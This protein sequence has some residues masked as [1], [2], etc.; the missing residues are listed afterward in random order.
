MT[1]NVTAF[2]FARGGSKGF[3]GKNVAPLAGKP[4]I[5]HAI[6][7]A[8]AANSV[9]RVVVSTDDEGIA[10]TARK[11]GAEV[12][13]MR[14]AEL[15]TD[16]APEWLAWRHALDAVDAAGGPPVDVFVCVPTTAPLRVPEDIDACV[17]RFL[18]GD[19]DVVLTVAPATRNP[20]FNMVTVDGAGRAALVIPSAEALHNRQAA[21]AIFDITTVCYA[22]RPAFVR[23]ADDMFAGTVGAVEVPP[24][25]AVDI[26]TALDLAVAEALWKARDDGDRP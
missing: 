23:E 22:A 7:A 26:D 20:Y 6:E 17:E 2:I 4:L 12:P 19:V 24:E 1:P 11:W 10:E 21:P 15:A 5:A 9:G 8:K 16:T 3:P 13:F 18:Q 25:R 14:P